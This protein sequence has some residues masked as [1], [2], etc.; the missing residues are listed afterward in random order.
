MKRFPHLFT[1]LSLSP[2][3]F[4]MEYHVSPSGLN[5]NDGSPT[6]PIATISA[7]AQLAQPGDTITVHAGVYRERV[8]PPRGGTS[9]TERIVYRAAPGETVVIK[10]SEIVRGWRPYAN[11]VWQVTLP[12]TF[13]GTVNPYEEL[14]A[15]DW[16]TD[17]GRSHHTGEIYIDGKSLR[18]THSLEGVLHPEPFPL[19]RDQDASTWTWFCKNGVH[20]TTLYANFRGLN[21]NEQL[22]EINVRDSCFYPDQ[23]GRDYITVKGFR[24]CH[25]ATQWAAPTAEQIGLIGT[26]WSKGWIIEDNVISDQSRPTAADELSG[27]KWL[28]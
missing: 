14:I 26:H 7:A 22:V 23:P 27:E 17:L 28:G 20:G 21:P 24:M 6:R 5:T 4:A 8:T 3:V 9:D 19:S 13:F 16:F 12:R 25:A 15:G 11:D 2:A 10:G 18:E 1:L